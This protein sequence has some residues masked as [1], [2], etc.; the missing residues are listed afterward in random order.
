VK[1]T[2]RQSDGLHGAEPPV[3]LFRGRHLQF[4]LISPSIITGQ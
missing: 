4:H 1:R 2:I 3:G